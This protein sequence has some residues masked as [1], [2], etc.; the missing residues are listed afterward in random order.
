MLPLA[1]LGLASSPQEQEC[2]TRAGRGRT[3][4]GAQHH[5]SPHS[6]H[7]WSLHSPGREGSLGIQS[8]TA[9]E[10]A[11]HLTEPAELLTPHCLTSRQLRAD[12]YNHRLESTQ[13][14]PAHLPTHGSCHH[15]SPQKV[16]VRLR[17]CSF[18]FPSP[19][20]S[21]K[22][23]LSHHR[24]FLSLLDARVLRHLLTTAINYCDT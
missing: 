4:R 24:F 9:L 11:G 14:P 16:E 3:T 10:H 19:V 1:V 22:I 21:Y 20:T 17:T 6:Q 2:R 7:R 12:L 8:S 23:Q 18:P 15:Y 13:P 5:R